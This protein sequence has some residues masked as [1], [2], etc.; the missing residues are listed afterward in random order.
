MRNRMLKY[1]IRKVFGLLGL[2]I[3]R[4]KNMKTIDSFMCTQEWLDLSSAINE[5]FI[6]KRVGFS[7]ESPQSVLGYL[8]PYRIRQYHSLTKTCDELN[9]QLSSSNVADVGTGVGYFLKHLHERYHPQELWGFDMK[10]DDLEIAAH[11]CPSAKLERKSFE[12]LPEGRFDVIFLMQV[13]EHVTAP[14]EVIQTIMKA[15]RPG[16]CLIITV[17]DGRTDQLIAG[18]FYPSMK[19]YWGHINFWSIESWRIFMQMHFHDMLPI[20]GALPVE[21]CN[22]FAIL[23]KPQSA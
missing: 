20:T 15:L 12:D 13:L 14:I 10:T 8:S 7:W 16:G 23:K 6:R 4:T 17:P 18:E 22:L 21:T 3:T 11:L 19:S 2:S 1:L 9:I 5:F